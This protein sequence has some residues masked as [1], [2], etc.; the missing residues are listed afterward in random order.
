MKQIQDLQN[1]L[2]LLDNMIDDPAKHT[3]DERV[4]IISRAIRIIAAQVQGHYN[5]IGLLKASVDELKKMVTSVDNKLFGDMDSPGVIY[6]LKTQISA[7]RD[8]LANFTRL[9]WAVL[10]SI[11]IDI[12]L[13]Y[14]NVV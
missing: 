1:A 11:V 2:S 13:R 9:L 3:I 12:V 6:E 8:S 14:F 7:V 4:A 5:D 10:A